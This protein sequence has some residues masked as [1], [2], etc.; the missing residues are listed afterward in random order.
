M[1][2]STTAEMEQ[3]AAAPLRVLQVTPRFHPH[4]GGIETHVYEV[5]RR[6]AARG[7]DVTV[8]TTDP[9]HEFPEDEI[10]EGIRVRRVSA[11]PADRDY[12]LAPAIW[13]VMMS[14]QWDVVH[15]QG[16]HTFVAPLGMFS[17][18]RAGA[19]YVVTF[20]TGGDTTPVRKAIRGAQWQALRPLFSRAER[21]IGPSNWEVDYFRKALRLPRERFSVIPNGAQRLP[22]MTPAQLTRRPDPLIVSVGRLVRYKGHHRVIAAMPYI[23]KVIPGARLRIVGIGPYESE[24]RQQVEQLGLGDHIEIAGIP[25]GDAA[26]MASILAQASLVTLLSE[27]EAQGLAVMEALSLGRPVLVADSTALSELAARGVARSISLQSSASQTAQAILRQ[28]SDPLIPN[29]VT[30]PTWD[31]CVN[32][33]L[34]VYSAVAHRT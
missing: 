21:L 33:L 32:E 26:G 6:M 11:W 15:C 20:H 13:R 10:I 1:A 30:L 19:P 23:L 7:I 9:K 22:T 29:R 5:G 18:Q 17:A 4:I 16:T 14:R 27:H 2:T 12:Y 31:N 28:L 3:R 25:P 8:L 34:A 24:L